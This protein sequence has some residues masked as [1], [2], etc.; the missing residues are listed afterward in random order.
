MAESETELQDAGSLMRRAFEAIAA[1]DLDAL[2][3]AWHEDVEEDFVALE[4]VRGKEA[5]TA[6]F[7]EYFAAMPDMEFTVERVISVDENTAVGE[8]SMRGTFNGGP[9]QGIEPTGRELA[10]R[11][12]DVME[13]EDGLLRRNTIYYDGLRFA[14]QVGLLPSEGS[15][16]DRAMLAALNTLS[17]AK[18]RLRR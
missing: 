15:A 9:F 11:G 14:R 8:W 5:A 3:G 10:L 17:R 6:F 1:K 18:N 13:F 16:P 4:P 2:R 12:I 7:A